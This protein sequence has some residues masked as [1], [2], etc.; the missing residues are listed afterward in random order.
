M[1]RVE[2]LLGPSTITEEDDQ[3]VLFGSSVRASNHFSDT[4]RHRTDHLA[5]KVSS[6]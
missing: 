1:E 4:I 6:L 2:M 3:R 5:I